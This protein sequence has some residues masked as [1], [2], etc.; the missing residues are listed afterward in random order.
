MSHNFNP[1]IQN[2]Q[3][4]KILRETLQPYHM[5]DPVVLLFISHYLHCRSVPQASRLAGIGGVDGKNLFNRPDIYNAI[6]RLTS[7]AVVKFGYDA[8]EV[9]ER[10]KELAFFD[11]IDLV[12]EDGTYKKSLHDLNPETRRV[13]KKLKVK[14]VFEPDMNGVPQ[15]RGEVIEYEFWD[16]PRS[17]ELLGREKETFKK[18]TVVEHNVSKDAR[19]WLL[20]SA[21]RGDQAR[22]AID[23]TPVVEIPHVPQFNFTKVT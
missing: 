7:E 13:I 2:E 19:N 23:V 18:T 5:T 10:V 8:A 21:D 22:K 4:Q 11:P 15:Y 17:L 20:A 3:A 1:D 12:N 16:K 6:S 9:V 14:N